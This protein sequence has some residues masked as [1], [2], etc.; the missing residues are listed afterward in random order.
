MGLMDTIKGML[1]GKGGA[2]GTTDLMSVVT[3]L[4]SGS[5]D[6]GAKLGGLPGILQKFTD[7]GMGDK[8]QSG[9]ARART[10]RSAV[11]RSRRRSARTRSRRWPP[12]P[13]VR[14]PR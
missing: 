13:V 3:G 10:L 11:T 12:R 6:I 5:G 8:V 7:N 2:S 14:P 4:F 1:G 9:P